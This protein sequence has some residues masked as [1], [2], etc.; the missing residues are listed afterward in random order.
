MWLIKPAMEYLIW[1]HC[2]L[3][4]LKGHVTKCNLFLLMQWDIILLSYKRTPSISLRHA[5]VCV[6]VCVCVCVV[7]DSVGACRRARYISLSYV[8]TAVGWFVP[9]TCVTRGWPSMKGGRQPAPIIL[10]VKDHQW[11][12]HSPRAFVPL[13]SHG[14]APSLWLQVKWVSSNVRSSLNRYQ[15]VTI[16]MSTRKRKYG[17][18]WTGQL[19]YS[20][21][22]YY[23]T[24]IGLNVKIWPP[25]FNYVENR[26]FLLLFGGLNIKTSGHAWW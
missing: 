1:C 23:D 17:R 4:W 6:S 7:E 18:I 22:C 12:V 20:S 24:I 5:E 25:P 19:V 2:P 9:F 21:L 13:W 3:P 26:W 14:R 15:Y 11:H 8:L 16:G 10:T